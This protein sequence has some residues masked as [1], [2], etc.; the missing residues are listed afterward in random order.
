MKK[1]CFCCENGV[2]KLRKMHIES[3]KKFGWYAHYIEDDK[4]FPFNINFH[5]HGLN[6]FDHLDLQVCLPIDVKIIHQIFFEIIDRIKN[7][8]KFYENKKYSNIIKEFDVIFISVVEDN[9][10]VLRLIL[11]DSLGNL[12]VDKMEE[13]YRKQY[14]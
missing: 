6:K 4:N 7:K 12:D 10:N 8:E 1:N 2:D 3:L 9:R 13:R 11:P 5:T 14:D